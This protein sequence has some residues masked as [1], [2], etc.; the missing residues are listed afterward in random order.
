MATLNSTKELR[1]T[2]KTLYE[3]NSTWRTHWKEISEYL[4]PRRGIFLT[5]E[6]EKAG[7]GE[8]K[9]G[10][11]INTKVLRAR[12]V[13]AAGMLTGMTPP[14]RP[15]FRLSLPDPELLEFHPVRAWLEVVQ[16]AMQTILQRSNFYAAVHNMYRE[17]G[18]FGFNAML[19][20]EDWKTVIR[21][22]PMTIGEC[23]ITMDS[24]YRPEALYRQFWM[25]GLQLTQEF[26]EEVLS[27]TII[28]AIKAKPEQN[29]LVH[30]AVF[31]RNRRNVLIGGALNSM[32]ASVY[33]L[34]N[35]QPE[36]Q[37]AILRESGYVSRPFV[38]PRWDVV[39]TE[40]Y[41]DCPGIE[42]L[43]DVKQLQKME[44]D[45]LMA[46]D[47][48]INPPMN[49]PVSMKQTGGNLL[50]GG[51][52]YIDVQQGQQGFTPTL[53]VRPNLEAMAFE[54]DR[55]ERRIDEHFFVDLFLAVTRED[56]NMTAT[57]VS[58]RMAERLQQ[59]GP[60]LERLQSELL[61][62]VIDR[63]FTIMNNMGLV[64]PA[65]PEIQGMEYKVEYIS[66]LAQAQRLSG[67]VAV[68]QLVGFVGNLAGAVPSV[69]DKLDADQAVD[70][71]AEMLGTP[72]SIVRSDDDV[73]EIRV[74]RAEAEAQQAQ[75]QQQAI[76]AEGAKVM[77]ETP[78]GKGSALDAVLGGITGAA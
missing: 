39:G 74:A 77:S 3:D 9:D 49:A 56:K 68:E 65:P 58:E 75:L 64:P 55:V 48:E 12:R 6:Q 45:K 40:T 28:A 20:E 23:Y 22:R 26:G 50:P 27:P 63:V 42:T 44:A 30:H 61:D 7:T 14:T 29:F 71:Y 38:S 2:W 24:T 73:E 53:V 51:V 43:A 32:Y 1:R 21:C 37:W 47:K 16:Q 18:L 78:L 60:A 17:L 41:G 70:E 15:W 25:T 34:E 76:A 19:I 13:M 62:P 69:L 33:Y 8:K 5:N 54:L 36:G 57:E 59:L 10:K 35:E 67:T 11:I 66:V 4:L 46:L 31:P 72:S 52:N